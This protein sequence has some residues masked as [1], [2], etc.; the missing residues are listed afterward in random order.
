MG[1]IVAYKKIYEAFR[2]SVE[3]WGGTGA[4][5]EKSQC[6]CGSKALK[7]TG[8]CNKGYENE[9]YDETHDKCICT[10]EKKHTDK[11]R[12]S[13]TLK[14]LISEATKIP[15]LGFNSGK[16]DLTFVINAMRNR[17]G[18][19]HRPSSDATGLL[20]QPQ[21]N[22][23]K[24]GKVI[25]KGS[26]Y[27]STEI[28]KYVF[29]DARMYVPPNVSLD[30][31]GK[32][33][34]AKV[35]KGLFPYDWFDCLEKM[36]N[37]EFP[38]IEAFANKMRCSMPTQREYDEALEVWNEKGFKTFGEYMMYYCE[39]DVDVLI[40]G[41]NNYRQQFW[42]SA[43]IEVL[44]FVSISQQAFTNLLKN[45]VDWEQYPLYYINDEKELEMID[46]SLHGGN[47]Q[48]FIYDMRR[49]MESPY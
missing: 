32:M 16:Y 45:H 36:N 35:E 12:Y 37:T 4:P 44:S 21:K 22:K 10:L 47:C 24:L 13:Q 41:L 30:K 48:V 29:L 14:S 46:K 7:H 11:C 5:W 1:E 49:V 26:G 20:A 23:L 28:G 15:I 6:N 38:P 42:D 40:E 27:M 39:L 25:P 3:L 8:Y 9:T 43:K 19:V 17:T 2:D 18:T 33:F 34:K 31:F